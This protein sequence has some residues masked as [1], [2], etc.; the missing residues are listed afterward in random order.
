MVPS[1]YLFA[2]L[3][4]MHEVDGSNVLD[5]VENGRFHGSPWRVG[6]APDMELGPEERDKEYKSNG[7]DKHDCGHQE[8]V[9]VLYGSRNGQGYREDN[10]CERV[11]PHDKVKVPPSIIAQRSIGRAVLR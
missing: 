3:S 7:T 5:A 9:I 10:A 1:M 4:T 2:I 11:S 6:G 8:E